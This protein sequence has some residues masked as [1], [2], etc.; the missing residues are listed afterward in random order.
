MC[1]TPLKAFRRMMDDRY[2]INVYPRRPTRDV[3][4]ELGRERTDR[5][6]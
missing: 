1:E 3:K 5:L 6:R 4:L 2:I